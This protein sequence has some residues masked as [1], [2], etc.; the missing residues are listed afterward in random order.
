MAPVDLRTALAPQNGL[1]SVDG[2]RLGSARITTVFTGLLPGGVLQLR[3]A[4]AQPGRFVSDTTPLDAVEVTGTLVP[5]VLGAPGL[6][7]HAWFFLV[8]G[9]ADVVATLTGMPDPWTPPVS[10]AGTAGSLS[11]MWPSAAPSSP[12]T[13]A[14]GPVLARHSTPCCSTTRRPTRPPPHPLR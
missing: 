11:P 1:L 10:F 8:D 3:E 9:T 5:T 12:S 14:P 6:A 2:D 4:G 7:V 13:P